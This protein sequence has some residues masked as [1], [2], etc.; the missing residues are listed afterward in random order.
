MTLRFAPL[1]ATALAL[2][3]APALAQDS[4]DSEPPPVPEAS[5]YDA[6]EVPPIPEDAAPYTAPQAAGAA[7]ESAAP[8]AQRAMPLSPFSLEQ[9]NG[10]LTHCRGVF[11]QA[12]AS[13]GGGSGLPDACETQ[14]QQFERTYV[15]P[16]DGS[17]AAPVVLVRVPVARAPVSA[18][19]DGDFEE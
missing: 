13:L 1:L 9:R 2:A 5:A 19:A 12:G 4:I 8:Q 17:D 3:A 6:G 14:L 10:W 16:A 11:R 18:P 15:A 7:V